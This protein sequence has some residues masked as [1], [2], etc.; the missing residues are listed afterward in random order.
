MLNKIIKTVEAYYDINADVLDVKQK[1][2]L[3]AQIEYLKCLENSKIKKRD[4][5]VTRKEFLKLYNTAMEMICYY[6]GSD[7]KERFNHLYGYPVEVHWN[8]VYCDCSD[9]ATAWNHI[10]S[11]IEGVI[12]EE[13]E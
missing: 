12:K 13:D 7:E 3:K 8:G 5:K 6:D 11:N 2:D 4:E 1:A 10:V 9:G